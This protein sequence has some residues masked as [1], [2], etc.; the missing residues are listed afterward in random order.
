M[1]VTDVLRDRMQ[2]P[3]GLQR[4]LTVSVAAH[5]ALAA[6][7]IVA[8]GGLL[9]RDTRPAT[10]MTI[11]LGGGGERAENGGMTPMGGRP[12]QEV[13]PPDEP[14]KR[15]AIR[16][17]AAKAPEMTMPLPN[18][19]VTKTAPPPS[20]PVKSAPEEARGK[21]PTRGAQ[22]MS[23]SAI[24]DT[25][26]RGQGFGLSSGGGPGSGSTLDVANFCCPEYIATMMMSIR[27]AWNMNQGMTGQ[28]V[29]KFTIQ[30]DGRLTDVSVFQSSGIATLDLA[31]Q[32]AVIQTAT[33]LPLPEQFPN[34]TL[35]V[36]LTFNY[37]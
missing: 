31:A 1:D 19:K 25:G 23:G 15:E 36:R 2:Q 37:Q 26:A 24:A 27:R 35:T 22:V 29:V 12:V 6:T 20:K 13:K 9:H 3:D 21:T 5:L 7:L 14:V 8:P 34:P 10:V 33:L 16:P 11:S 32:R 28:S 17:P 4:M 18:A 30:R